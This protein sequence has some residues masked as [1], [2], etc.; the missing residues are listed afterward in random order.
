MVLVEH[1]RRNAVSPS[2]NPLAFHSTTSRSNSSSPSSASAVSPP[3]SPSPSDIALL[4]GRGRHRDAPAHTRH[5]LSNY[6][7][8]AAPRRTVVPSEISS[9]HAPPTPRFA[10]QRTR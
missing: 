7:D 8:V 1:P 2:L 10:R 5:L 4:P 3:F 9:Q 6:T